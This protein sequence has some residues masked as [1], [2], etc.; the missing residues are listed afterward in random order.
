MVTRLIHRAT[1]STTI[2]LLN[3]MA[4]TMKLS[5]SQVY[6]ID[7]G[8]CYAT[9]YFLE[10]FCGIQWYGPTALNTVVPS[11]RTLIIMG[12]NIRRSPDLKH[13]YTVGGGWPIIH[14][15]WNQPTPDQWNLYWYRMQIG[16]EKWAGNHTIWTETVEEIFNDPEYQAV[17]RGKGSQ[18]C[19]TH[20]SKVGKRHGTG[21]P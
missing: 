13:R 20:A 16:G 6:S 7:Q 2:G 5:N 3:L 9:H 21:S 12:T 15:Q 1:V 18:L 11:R 17:G 4:R 14:I 10:Q 8:T 19:Y